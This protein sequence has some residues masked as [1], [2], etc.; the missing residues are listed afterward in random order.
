MRTNLLQC[1][2]CSML[3]MEGGR[4]QPR[5]LEQRPAKTLRTDIQAPIANQAATGTFSS[6]CNA[7]HAGHQHAWI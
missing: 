7:A 2:E 6:T 4:L 5:K 1:S 3:D